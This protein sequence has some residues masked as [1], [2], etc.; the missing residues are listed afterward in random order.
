[1]KRRI[2]SILLAII[3]IMSLSISAFAHSGRTDS[4]GG[5]KDNKNKSG[6]G[7]YHYHCGGYPAHLHSGGVCPY[8][9]TST[10]TTT[11]TYTPPKPVYATKITA[12]NVPTTINDGESTQLKGSVYPTNA[13]DKTIEWKSNNP[14]IVAVTSSG[15]LHAVGVGKATV[16]A[17]T[18][19]GTSST[20]TI[21]VKEV[22]AESIVIENKPTDMLIG[23]TKS[24][25][26]AFTPENTTNKNIEW[27]SDNAEIV[28]VTTDGKATAKAIGTATI[29]AT[30]GELTDI[31]VIEVLPIEAE[32]IEIIFPS[33]EA[34]STETNR[35]AEGNQ[36]E[37]KAVFT[38]E[39]TTDKT[40]TWSVSDTSIAEIDENG[41]LTA[42]NSGTVTIIAT[43]SNGVT[44]EIDIEVYSNTAAGVAGVGVVAVAVG[45]GYYFIRKRKK[46]AEIE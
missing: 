19:R 4:S 18:S 34:D 6:L 5:H 9:S 37:L 39:E 24:L 29:T 16:T 3:V 26:V 17:T 43:A 46:K 36:I 22:F 41:K 31:C 44:A 40:I 23:E 32:S 15:S 27:N 1:M 25:S 21:T 28:S 8:R 11:K 13:E 42:I 2:P 35:V 12:V 45:G 10:T 7:S 33:E 38:P 30:H 20:F 14:E